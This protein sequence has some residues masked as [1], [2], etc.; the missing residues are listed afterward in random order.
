MSSTPRKL[1]YINVTTAFL[2]DMRTE[3]YK[4]NKPERSEDLQNFLS[5]QPADHKLVLP[6]HYRC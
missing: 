1:K 3:R 6:N 5:S 2:K 4:V